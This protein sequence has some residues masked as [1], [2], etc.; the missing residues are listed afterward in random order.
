MNSLSKLLFLTNLD[1]QRLINEEIS[2]VLSLS[3][4]ILILI[5]SCKKSNSGGSSSAATS[6][7]SAVVSYS[8]QQKIVDSFITTAPTSWIPLRRQFTIPPPVRPYTIVTP[9]NSSTRARTPI[10]LTT[11]ST[12]SPTEIM[13]TITCCLMTVRVGSPGYQPERQRVCDL[14]F[15]SQ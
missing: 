5:F 7:L 4:L 15:L 2:L 14:L 10:L 9:F 6:Y 3:A 12:M 13:A 8:P 1:Q 11:I